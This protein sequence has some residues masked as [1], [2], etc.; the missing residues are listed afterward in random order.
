MGTDLRTAI[1]DSEDFENTGEARFRLD[2]CPT[3]LT[4]VHLQECYE[5]GFAVPFHTSCTCWFLLVLHGRSYAKILTTKNLS[6]LADSW[7]ATL[8]QFVFNES[9]FQPLY[10]GYKLPAGADFNR[11]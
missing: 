10:G 7:P 6:L 1:V 2:N 11:W 3:P 4:H 5:G 9:Q 8:Q